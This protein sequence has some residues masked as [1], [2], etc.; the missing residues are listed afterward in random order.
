MAECCPVP[1]SLTCAKSDQ[2]AVEGKQQ[3][4]EAGSRLTEEGKK[5]FMC[6]N[7]GCKDVKRAGNFFCSKSKNEEGVFF[8]GLIQIKESSELLLMAGRKVSF[9][10]FPLFC[11]IVMLLV[12]FL[13]KESFTPFL[14]RM[15]APGKLMD[16]LKVKY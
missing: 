11:V 16:L 2:P 5:S 7:L 15:Q 13:K 6:Q 9:A 10:L 8:N 1:C 14:Q 3:K 12:T 4:K